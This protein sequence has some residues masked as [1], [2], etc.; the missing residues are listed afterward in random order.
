MKSNSYLVQGKPMHCFL[1]IAIPTYNNPILLKTAIDSVIKQELFG[2]CQL[3]I[4]DNDCSGEETTTSLL[5]KEYRNNSNILYYRN[6]SNLGMYGNWN[7]CFELAD[8]EYVLLLHNDDYLLPGC[9]K[10]VIEVLKKNFYPALYLNRSSGIIPSKQF[11]VERWGKKRKLLNA[12]FRKKNIEHKVA[13]K[14][15][16]FGFCLTAPT[17]FV[18]SKELFLQGYKFTLESTKWP[19]DPEL[20]LKL[21]ENNLLYMSENIFVVKVENGENEGSKKDV[22]IPLTVNFGHLCFKVYRHKK[23]FFKN[24]LIYVRLRLIAQSFKIQ[25]AAQIRAYIPAFYF[26]S[27]SY[28]IYRF[29]LKLSIISFI[30]R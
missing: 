12:L 13:L 8:C 20:Q 25:D 19:S 29:L 22:T 21:A 6:Y 2:L 18:M 23:Y 15:T 5:M 10:Y 24:L 30:L 7:Q 14:D 3:L 11:A 16:L 27:I 28:H 17:G 4:S 9:I 26:T 1:T